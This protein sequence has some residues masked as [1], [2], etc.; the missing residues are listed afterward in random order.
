MADRFEP[1]AVAFARDQSAEITPTRDGRS[2]T[3]W[4]Q[5]PDFDPAHDTVFVSMHG[6]Q[7]WAMKDFQ[8]W[9]PKLQDRRYAFLGIQWWYGRSAESIGYAKPREIYGWIR[10]ELEKRG[11]PKKHVIFTGFSMGSANSYAVTFLDRMQ[12]EPY[13]AITISNAGYLEADYPPNRG[14]LDKRGGPT[15]FAGAHWILYCAEKDEQR[16]QTCE[17]MVHT[18]ETLEELGATVEKFIRDPSS[19]HGGF[20]KTQNHG[21]ALDLADRIIADESR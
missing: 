2:F 8:V 7:G 6:H 4:W 9:H 15:P 12:A 21:P 10:D 5:K 13:F 11:I 19:G 18:K 3:L 17:N 16:P 20:M 1:G 14:F